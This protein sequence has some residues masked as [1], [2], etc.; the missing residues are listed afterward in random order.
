MN[1]LQNVYKLFHFNMTICPLYLVKQKITQKQ[2]TAYAV[3]SVE[4]IV[5]DFRRKSF[6]VRYLPYLLENS[7]SSLIGENL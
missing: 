4:P 6:N 2:P 3:H 7:L 5:S 1:T